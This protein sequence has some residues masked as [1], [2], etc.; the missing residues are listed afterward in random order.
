M[1]RIKKKE[2]LPPAHAKAKAKARGINKQRGI[3]SRESE[4]TSL[5]YQLPVIFNNSVCAYAKMED[6]G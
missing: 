4:V 2:M 6:D 3:K 5:S 1:L